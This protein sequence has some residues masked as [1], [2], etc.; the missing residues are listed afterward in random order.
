MLSRLNQ[1]APAAWFSD[2]NWSPFGV[3][4]FSQTAIFGFI[5]D[6]GTGGNHG[7]HVANPMQVDIFADHSSSTAI[8]RVNANRLE[9]W[10]EPRQ[11]FNTSNCP[12]QVSCSPT[13]QSGRKVAISHHSGFSRF[14]TRR[15]PLDVGVAGSTDL[16]S[17]KVLSRRLDFVSDTPRS[18]P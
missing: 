5:N 16:I 8:S 6:T 14:H 11:H 10:G 17:K 9:G 13:L 12:P 3:P 7:C 15:E 18:M 1:T 4:T 2:Q